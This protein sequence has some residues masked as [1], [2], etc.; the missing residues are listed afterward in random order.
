MGWVP[1]GRVRKCVP[2]TTTWATSH[3]MPGLLVA[4]HDTIVLLKIKA[5]WEVKFPLSFA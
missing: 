3:S 5:W 4:V 2:P 1:R